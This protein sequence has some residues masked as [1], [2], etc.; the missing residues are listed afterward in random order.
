MHVKITGAVHARYQITKQSSTRLLCY[1]ANTGFG[2]AYAAEMWFEGFG[3]LPS[4][5]I[6]EPRPN[7]PTRHVSLARSTTVTVSYVSPD[8]TV[9][10]AGY[11]QFTDGH[12]GHFGSGTMTA[13][14]AMTK[15][16]LNATLVWPT[17][18]AP[19][20]PIHLTASWDCA[21]HASRKTR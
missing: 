17:L 7:E 13:N 3:M 1:T 21:R 20:R 11:L 2:S 5:S 4:L 8:G 10:A 9:W 6:V 19:V 18:G 14:P 12:S 16:R 15:G